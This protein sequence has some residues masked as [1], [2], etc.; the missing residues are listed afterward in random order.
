MSPV[1]KRAALG[2]LTAAGLVL[3][4]VGLWLLAH[5]GLSGTATFTATPSS[6]RIVVLDPAVLNRVDSPVSITARA[7]DGGE[8]WI[9]RGTP[10][11]A[12]SLAGK[13]AA[14]SVTGVS[15]G[16]WQLETGQRGSGSAPELA[17]ADVW[18]QQA[19]GKGSAGMEVRQEDAP[20]AVVIATA[21]GKPADLAELTV[22]WERQAWSVEALTALLLGLLMTAAGVGFL[23]QPGSA[24]RR[25]GAAEHARPD[26]PAPTADRP[27][28]PTAVLPDAPTAVLPDAPTAAARPTSEE[29]R[30]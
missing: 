30:P 5:L 9:G 2:V 22:E 17:S 29:G 10:S 8:V 24:R 27:D 23:W 19:S 21:S 12:A 3:A 16:G 11:D 18:R 20:E 28:A 6:S 7:K 4:G 1:S 25:S 14:T 26:A 13:A 15:V